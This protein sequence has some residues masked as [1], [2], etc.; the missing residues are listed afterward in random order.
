MMDKQELANR[1]SSMPD[2]VV[3]RMNQAEITAI[4]EQFRERADAA[5]QLF[6]ARAPFATP[7]ESIATYRARLLNSLKGFTPEDSPFRSINFGAFSDSAVLANFEQQLVDKT[8]ET[9]LAPEGP[10]RSVMRVDSETGARRRHFYGG[11][12]ACWDQFK[13]PTQKFLKGFGC[14]ASGVRAPGAH[15][16]VPVAVT[17]SD[18]SVRSL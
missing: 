17:M 10:L 13:P 4:T 1:V 18:G 15:G 12:G 3:A 2:S 9:F 16:P 6:E 7:G 8:I 11:P 14:T 5:F